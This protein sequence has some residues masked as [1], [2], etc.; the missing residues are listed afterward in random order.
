[1]AISQ[2]IISV[3]EDW[4]QR[5]KGNF[6]FN[7]SLI[8]RRACPYC[9]V[10]AKTSVKAIKRKAKE[11]IK[12]EKEKEKNNANRRQYS[13]RIVSSFQN[14]IMALR[15]IFGGLCS[16]FCNKSYSFATTEHA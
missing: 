8:P 11:K 5:E 12:A 9:S 16:A 10:E 1:M 6:I 4:A 2:V 3:A 15:C 13:E 14:W 7:Y